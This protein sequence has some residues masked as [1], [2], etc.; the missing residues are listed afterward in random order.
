MAHV[1]AA[2]MQDPRVR[3]LPRIETRAIPGERDVVR[4]DI[5]VDLI[6]QQT[7]L[8]L[9]FDVKLGTT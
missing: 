6:D 7:P 3:N 8:N 1:R 9:V 2:L 5:D 4:L